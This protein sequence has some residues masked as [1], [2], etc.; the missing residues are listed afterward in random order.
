LQRTK[1][2]AAFA[3]GWSRILIAT[4]VASRGLDIP[5]VS[6]VVNYDLPEDVDTY[7]HRI[8][9]TARAGKDGVAATLVGEAEIKEFHKLQRALPVEVRRSRLPLSA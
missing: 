5:D 7:V 2:L 3:H 9:R 4:N 1:T 6:H 8:G